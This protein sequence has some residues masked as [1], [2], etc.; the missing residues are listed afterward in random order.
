MV[1]CLIFKSFSHFEFILGHAVR[2]DWELGVSRYR[3]LPLEWISNEILQCGT[4][5]YV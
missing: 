3:L 2:V 1:S 5:N 4:V